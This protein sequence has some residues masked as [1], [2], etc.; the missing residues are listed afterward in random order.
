[1]K[2]GFLNLLKPPGMSSH[3]MVNSVRRSLGI[4]KVGHAGTLDPGAAGVLPVAVGRATRLLEYLMDHTKEYRAEL[5]FGFSTD[6]GD[7]TGKVLERR[8]EYAMPTVEEIEGVLRLFR[9][10]ITQ[11]PP[12]FSAIKIDG[13]KAY[14]LART[15]Q[16]VTIPERHVS[17]TRLEL[18]GM[19]NGQLLLDVECSKGTY[20]RS[21]CL[22]MGK[23]FGIPSTMGFLL[24]KRV[25]DFALEHS[26]TLEELMEYDEKALLHPSDCLSGLFRYQ[27]PKHR[28]N[29]F[30]N[31]LATTVGE[32]EL[33]TRFCVYCGEDFLGIGS[34]N[35]EECA[36]LPVKVY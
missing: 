32:R 25:G 24:R 12:K 3:D 36:V 22:D 18:V 27:L 17:I 34:Y 2:D 33:P 28:R 20:I 7:D 16:E 14:D 35:K 15:N 6:S 13:K 30:C 9:G 8:E 10:E 21:L 1:M 11:T 19:K 5:L 4:K 31:G 29:A 23:A 26:I